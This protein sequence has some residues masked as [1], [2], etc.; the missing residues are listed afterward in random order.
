MRRT[1]SQNARLHGLINELK[2]DKET[3]EDLVY[4][5]TQGRSA[6]SSDMSVDECQS[7]IGY[8]EYTKPR[9]TDKANKQRKKILSI[10]H[11][12]DWRV[13]EKVDFK[14]LED[15]LLKYGYLHKPLNDYT[16]DELPTLVT[17]FQNL[18]KSYYAK[19]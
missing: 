19:R 7:L 17:Q 6:S 14:R 16:E 3:K 15:Y 4:T 10:C 18:L 1:I 2:I 8:L 13:N 9:K 12:M 11:E 5:F